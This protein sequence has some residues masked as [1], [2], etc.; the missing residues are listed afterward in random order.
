LHDLNNWRG[1]MFLESVAKVVSIIRDVRLQSVLETE[2][3]ENQNGI[4]PE[5]GTRD[6]I[7]LLEI[8]FLHKRKERGLSSCVVF[9]DLVKAFDTV[10]ISVVHSPE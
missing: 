9:I 2:C 4:H 7:F 8:A 6:G 3:H 10:P 5:R 1:I